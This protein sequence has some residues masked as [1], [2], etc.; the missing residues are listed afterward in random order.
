M[1]HEAV[2]LLGLY[3]N[4]HPQHQHKLCWG[5]APSLLQRLC[6]VPTQYLHT[7]EPCRWCMLAK[8]QPA[9]STCHDQ[10]A[11]AQV[12]G[13]G[14][15]DSAQ[16]WQQGAVHSESNTPRTPASNETPANISDTFMDY[17]MSDSPELSPVA[18]RVHSDSAR[19]PT[20]EERRSV[21]LSS[22][23]CPYTCPSEGEESTSQYAAD[24][25]CCG[26]ADAPSAPA[27]LQHVLYP[28]LL[29]ACLDAPRNCQAVIDTLGAQG[30]L[31]Y[32]TTY[33]PPN[34]AASC[35]GHQRM[36]AH[37]ATCSR[38]ASVSPRTA[39]SVPELQHDLF[40]SAMCATGCSSPQGVAGSGGTASTVA[41][42]R[43]RLVEAEGQEWQVDLGPLD[44]RFHPQHRIHASAWWRAREQ[45]MAASVG[46]SC[47]RGGASNNPAP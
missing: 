3:A 33:A 23:A 18:M 45:L 35:V 4:G 13:T 47:A 25:C 12:G 29:A 11:V 34:P 2:L 27:Y 21:S 44:G 37:S 40:H 30:I 5:P 32:C 31:G 28:T 39:A 41:A 16:C 38:T 42:E 22:I 14:S 19:S 43:V 7:S 9:S 6:T 1:L 20:L 26:R 36:S 46:A 10:H 8:S 17:E 24:A 15:V